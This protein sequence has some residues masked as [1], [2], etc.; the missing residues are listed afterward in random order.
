MPDSQWQ[1]NPELARSVVRKGLVVLKDAAGAVKEQIGDLSV[2]SEEER[3]DLSLFRSRIE[4]YGTLKTHKRP[5]CLGV[6]GP[7]GSG[8]SFA[9]SQILG[10]TGHSL[11]VINLSQ[12]E[13]PGEL[14]SAL[15]EVARWSLGKMPIVFFDEFDSALDG[16]PLGWLQWLLA[17]MQDG[18]TL[19]H[20]HAIEMKRA[21]FV[22]AGGT[23]DT[24]EEFPAAHADYF[25]RAKGPDFI[26]RLRGHMNVR[27]VNEWPYRR[28]RRATV[29]RLAIERVASSLLDASGKIP[30]D[31]MSDEFVD[32]ILSVGRFVHG[33][34]SVEALVEMSTNPD[35]TSFTKDKLPAREVLA[36]HVDPGRLGGLAI[37]LSAGGDRKDQE[38][39]DRYKA[40]EDCWT[41]VA[42]RL[43][44]LGAGLVYGGDLRSEGFTK[45]L[46]EAE[47][48]L[49]KPIDREDS[50]ADAFAPPA[51]VTC[52][53][54]D[55]I[56]V[57]SSRIDVRFPPGLTED[58]Y[59]RLGLPRGTDLSS[60]DRSAGPVSDWK[61]SPDW[62][63][64]L[65]R[66]LTLFRLR[67]D[68]ACLTD[69]C[70]VF[71]GREKRF[72]GRFPG[73]AEEVMLGLAT[74]SAIYICGGFGGAAEAVGKVLGLGPA[75][76]DVPDCLRVEEQGDETLESAVHAWGERFQ[77]PHL[78]DLPLDYA[79]LVAF[80][81][82]HALGGPRW[83]ENGLTAS[84]NRALFGSQDPM[85]ITRLV[86]QGLRLWFAGAR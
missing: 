68:I 57:S 50:V 22:F 43:M 75:W 18:V 55:P 24:Y 37:A 34:R 59:D 15:A 66:A 76:L 84:E 20:G 19:Y 11:R 23:A 32:R 41:A 1:D 48:R 5:L 80:L 54:S 69:A 45:R 65:G 51:R 4:A 82:D 78:D 25:R 86:V 56:A 33:A 7:P 77:V 29:L 36:T 46:L 72:S 53:P 71:G 17:P 44:E 31:R 85:E 3:R 64:R 52:Y 12:L 74:G 10:T 81:R 9:V 60:F 40:L 6:F 30:E 61:T 42:T 70:L 83:P 67:A 14:S 21:V 28:I 62:C 2:L 79:G 38:A 16:A 26:S 13:G 63:K 73:V 35:S 27:G 58:E 49:P 39:G 8:K 47:S